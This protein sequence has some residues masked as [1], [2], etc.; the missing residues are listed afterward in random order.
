MCLGY[1]HYSV[2]VSHHPHYLGITFMCFPSLVIVQ[3]LLTSQNPRIGR[4]FPSV[5]IVHTVF[6]FL[7]S[8]SYFL[9]LLCSYFC[10]WST[11]YSC[12]LFLIRSCLLILFPV[13]LPLSSKSC[14]CIFH[15]SMFVGL[16][17]FDFVTPPPSVCFI[18]C[19]VY[20]WSSCCVYCKFDFLVLTLRSCS[21]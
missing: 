2:R 16:F 10:V 11:H 17:C 8:S 4:S 7:V 21:R 19:I 13:P 15:L 14:I 20:V 12:F 3:L 18:L 1:V 6:S 9:T 5:F